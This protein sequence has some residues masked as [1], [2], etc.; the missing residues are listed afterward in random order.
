M[1]NAIELLSS[2]FRD[3]LEATDANLSLVQD[4]IEDAVAYTR[5]Y[6]GIESTDYHKVWYNPFVCPNAAE[7]PNV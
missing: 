3:L 5:T 7:W 4:E 6:L 1:K 2:H